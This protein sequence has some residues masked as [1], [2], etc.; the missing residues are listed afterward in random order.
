MSESR[1]ELVPAL[2]PAAMQIRRMGQTL[3]HYWTDALGY[4]KLLYVVGTVLLV[5]AIFH[6][7]VI[8]VTGGS[9]QGPVSWRKPITFGFSF[10]VTCWTLGWI[11]SYLPS[12]QRIGW[13]LSGGFSVPALGEVFLISMQQWRGV[14]S[15]F[16]F[17]TPF[18]DTVFTIMGN[19][20]T[21][22]AVIV[23]VL[24]V[25]TFVSLQ[26]PASLALAIRLGMVLLLAGQVTGV[27]IILFGT[28]QA[29]MGTAQVAGHVTREPNIY[30]LSGL[31]KVPH[32]LT[33]HGIQVLGLL[34]WVL[35]FTRWKERVRVSIVTIGAIGFV[36]VVLAM[37]VQTYSGLA[38][39]D[40]SLPLAL[41]LTVSACSLVA[42]YAA[43]AVAVWQTLSPLPTHK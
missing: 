36:G 22:I 19:L 13:I 32:A 37:L 2:H 23:L 41:L 27:L 4:Q 1:A 6:L 24:T 40:L 35:L 21:V 7:G 28:P 15:H 8:L 11:L 29:L 30:G 10:G 14:A 26:A 9:W 39:F 42:A 16:N 18:D 12:R 17:T 20:V 34:A 5:S 33:L 43:A 38:P 25:W 3:R 31:M